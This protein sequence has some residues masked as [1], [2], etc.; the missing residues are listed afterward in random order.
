MP[1]KAIF[2][3]RDDTLI[4]DPGY[5][6]RPDQVKLLPGVTEALIELKALGYKLIVASNQSGVARGIVTEKV[7]HQIHDRLKQLL[8][9]NAAPLDKI[10]YC[11]YHPD[12]VV[13][14]YRKESDLRKP[15]PGMLLLAAGEMDI[16]LT[17]SWLIGNSPRDIKAGAH[18]GCKTILIDHSARHKYLE[19]DQPKPDYRAVNMK[20][21]VNIIKKHLRS[22]G[23]LAPETIPTVLR[24]QS[25]PQDVEPQSLQP[26]HQPANRTD[27]QLSG[28][29]T[30]NLLNSILQQLRSM[31]RDTAFAEFSIMRLLAGALQI[32]VFFCLLISV[33]LLMS[34]TSTDNS[35]LIAIGFAIVFQTMALTFYMMQRRK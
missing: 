10:Y 11:P 21:A 12:G 1:D 2:L 13:A 24:P 4:E 33:W 32:I 16:D 26:L 6:N 8:A 20:E 18:V 9:E 17:Q 34:A 28:D 27:Q 25:Q 30:A 7:L 15:N 22:S 35:V 14:K 19:P 23:Q 31:Q 5:I 29:T 3:D